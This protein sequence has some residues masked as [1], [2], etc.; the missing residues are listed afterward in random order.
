M[1]GLQ[2]AAALHQAGDLGGARSLYEEILAQRPD[3]FQ[4]LHALG[5]IA[6]QCGDYAKA[7]DLIGTALV[8]SP[9]DAA[10]QANLGLTFLALQQASRAAACYARAIALQPDYAA[11][12]F[13]LGLALQSQ[14]DLTAAIA[15]YE[16]A[17]GINPAYAEAWSNRGNA[18]LALERANEAV[19]SYEKALAVEP[20]MASAHYNRAVALHGMGLL[21]EALLGYDRAVTLNPSYADAWSNRGI[22]LKSLWRL[23][24]ALGS[25][26]KAAQIDPH[27]IDAKRNIFWHHLAEL[28]DQ[29][30]AEQKS[31]ELLAVAIAQDAANLLTAGTISLFR[32][33]HDL[34]QIRHQLAAGHAAGELH[35]AASVLEDICARAADGDQRITLSAEETATLIQ[36]RSRPVLYRPTTGQS[37]SLNSDN[38]WAAIEERYLRATPEIVVID[39][40]LSPWALAELQRYCLTSAVWTREYPDQYLG[41]FADRGF[42]S[43]LHM[44]IAMELRARMPR[45]FANHPLEQL[46]GFKYAA[47]ASN[48]AARGIGVHADFALVNLNFWVAPDHANLDP[49]SGGLIVHHAPAPPSW[50]FREYN[51]NAARIREFL[52]QQ[53]SGHTQVPYRCNRAVLF[54]SNLF[55]ETD[56]IRFREGYENRRINITYLFG[57]GLRSI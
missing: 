26:T 31:A 23:D 51:N 54:N 10:A 8:H 40:L 49:L 38:D 43:P 27:H 24:E 5:I 48:P 21:Q 28:K 34:G 14:G 29:A 13:G 32:A 15:S 2:Q 4:A 46:W 44:M 39:D 16:K 11:A 1:T 9:E 55:H 12:H 47:S 6:Y 18:L 17:V 36:H 19:A 3:S 20:G 50:N 35:A 25:F 37:S 30:Q 45:I 22:A 53:K 33:R 52:G 41:A 56:A 7:A 57:R 42:F